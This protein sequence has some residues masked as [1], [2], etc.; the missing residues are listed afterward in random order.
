MSYVVLAREFS[1]VAGKIP[2]SASKHQST[3][4]EKAL[5]L[6]DFQ[7]EEVQLLGWR[8]C[9]QNRNMLDGLQDLFEPMDSKP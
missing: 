1:Q 9:H 5:L 2:W 4:K 3:E 7:V 6:G 8:V